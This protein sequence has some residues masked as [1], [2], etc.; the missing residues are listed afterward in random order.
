MRQ[1]PLGLRFGKLLL[2]AA[3]FFSMGTAGAGAQETTARLPLPIDEVREATVFSVTGPTATVLTGLLWPSSGPLTAWAPVFSSFQTDGTL[4]ESGTGAWIGPRP[5]RWLKVIKP[6]FVVGG[7]RV[8]MKTSPGAPQTRQLQVFWKGWQDG[9]ASG[10]VIVSRVYGAA[11]GA[12]DQVKIIELRLPERAV[13]VGLYGQ[14]SQSGVVQASLLVK[15]PAQPPA[16]APDSA[17][18][19]AV[20]SPSS[21]QSPFVGPALPAVP[22]APQPVPF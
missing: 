21:P 13:P 8:L 12:Q 5:A 22:P 17:S 18:A 9:E 3:T 16:K 4:K 19:P 6:G 15:L 10:P 1:N 7:F 11:A 2:L 20:R 14:S